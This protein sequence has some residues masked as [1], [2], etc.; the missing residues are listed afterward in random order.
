MIL[1]TNLP[2]SEISEGSE[3]SC[4]PKFWISN[5]GTLPRGSLTNAALT[6]GDFTSEAEFLAQ[7]EV[8]SY[9]VDELRMHVLATDNSQKFWKIKQKHKVENGVS[10]YSLAPDERDPK[11]YIEPYIFW[12]ANI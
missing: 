3:S 12:I 2:S 8:K 5:F 9:S 10:F 1:L 4:F 7:G 6:G 11:T